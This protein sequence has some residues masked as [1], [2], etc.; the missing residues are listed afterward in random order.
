[1]GRSIF[2]ESDA[3]LTALA[4]IASGIDGSLNTM[5]RASTAATA[6]RSR[7]YFRFLRFAASVM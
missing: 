7:L 1:M 3:R 4:E 2:R 5:T 6:I